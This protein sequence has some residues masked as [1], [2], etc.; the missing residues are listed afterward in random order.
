MS[1]NL[2]RNV[3]RANLAQPSPPKKNIYHTP[4]IVNTLQIQSHATKAHD[5]AI[6]DCRGQSNANASNMSGKYSGIQ[7]IIRLQCNLAE[8]VPCTAHSLNLVGQSAVG[9]FTLA[10]GFFMFLQDLYSFFSASTHRWKVLMNQL[11]RKILPTVK[12]MS[13]TRWSARADATMALVM[14]YNKINDASEETQ[15]TTMTGIL[16]GLWH[17]ILDRFHR[18]SQALQTLFY[19]LPDWPHCQSVPSKEVEKIT[20]VI[21]EGQEMAENLEQLSPQYAFS[22][23]IQAQETILWWKQ[24]KAVYHCDREC[25]NKHWHDQKVIC[26]AVQNIDHKDSKDADLEF[27]ASH[28][29]PD[30][31]NKLVKITGWKRIIG[32][33]RHVIEEIVKNKHNNLLPDI[34]SSFAGLDDSGSITAIPVKLRE[35]KR[36]K[37]AR[38]ASECYVSTTNES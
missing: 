15:P 12:H 32:E 21:S 10:I 7:A 3:I 36:A 5:I 22:Q 20:E 24:C 35:E 18:N 23:K 6:A 16:A 14:G 38:K 27:F 25:Q 1:R 2:W 17:R 9:C 26:V 11:S 13:E 37:A 34:Q 33:I 29:T 28:L 30:Q 31:Q 19:L 4:M 8:Y